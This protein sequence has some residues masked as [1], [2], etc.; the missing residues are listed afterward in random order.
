LPLTFHHLIPRTTHSR[1]YNKTKSK[2][3]LNKGIW[4]CRECHSGIH[5]HI[6]EETMALEYFTFDLLIA[7]EGVYKMAK[8]MSK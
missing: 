4:I 6:D 1:P 3:E 7:H 5:N 2:E 8:Y